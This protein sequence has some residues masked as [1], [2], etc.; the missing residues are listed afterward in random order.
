ML[1]FLFFIETEQKSKKSNALYCDDKTNIEEISPC[2]TNKN[3][4]KIVNKKLSQ[5]TLSEY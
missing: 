4:Q 1:F 2:Y 3:H 5:R